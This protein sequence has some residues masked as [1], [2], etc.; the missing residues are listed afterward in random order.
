MKRKALL[1]TDPNRPAVISG[2]NFNTLNRAQLDNPVS[3]RL[4]APDVDVGA[5]VGGM[6]AIGVIHPVGQVT[7]T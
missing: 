2:H 3:V 5:V 4:A 1:G 7:T 6:Q